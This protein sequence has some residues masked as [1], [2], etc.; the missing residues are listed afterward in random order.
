LSPERGGRL[1]SVMLRG[2]SRWEV[3]GW[4]FL[5]A[6]GLASRVAVA[7]RRSLW[8]DDGATLGAIALSPVE[9]WGERLS[10]GHFPWFFLLFQGWTWLAGL[11][12]AA[13]RAPFVLM[14]LAAIPLTAALAFEVAPKG[15]K[16]AA[17]WI[18]GALAAVHPSLLYLAAELRPYALLTLLG[19]GMILSLLRTARQLSGRAFLIIGALHWAI[20]NLHIGGALFS[21][22]LLG[23]AMALGWRQ[24]L[25]RSWLL[26]CWKSLW[27]PLALFAPMLWVYATN[28]DPTHGDKLE[29]LQP[30]AQFLRAT[31]QLMVGVDSVLM[32]LG[33]RGW[34]LWLGLAGPLAAALL[35]GSQDSREEGEGLGQR[36]AIGLLVMGVLG[37]PALALG[38]SWAGSSPIVGSARYYSAGLAPFI[39]L[40]GAGL[41]SG[42]SRKS[43]FYWVLSLLFLVILAA[44]APLAGRR[45]NELL[46]QSGEGFSEAAAWI[47]SHVPQDALIVVSHDQFVRELARFYLNE[48]RA[49]VFLPR[50][51]TAQEVREALSGQFAPGRDAAL[52]LYRTKPSRIEELVRRQIGFRG[53]A[54]RFRAGLALAVWLRRSERDGKT[55]KA[56]SASFGH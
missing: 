12:L 22:P 27:I 3:A 48:D 32:S 45:G 2:K 18:A 38:I 39:A 33:G 55:A 11:S 42:F 8:F 16:R 54:E 14:T 46:T 41:A 29:G 44:W 40:L 23:F 17:A 21:L 6:I 56:L 24:G 4:S 50:S 36:G 25:G 51:A 43:L 9:L 53:R 35:L 49:W 20:L 5:L 28:V 34:R 37:A 26:R 13:L 31:Y 30:G 10:N 52:L 1:F 19:G 15:R 47:E 7:A